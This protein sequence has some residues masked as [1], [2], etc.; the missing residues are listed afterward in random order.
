VLGFEVHIAN[1]GAPIRVELKTGA[2]LPDGSL[3]TILGRHEEEMIDTGGTVIPLFNGFVLPSGI[4]AGTYT[5]E[6]ALLEPE[7]GETLSRQSVTLTLEP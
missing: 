7:L 5:I 4:P 1:E 6:V 3:V 2:R